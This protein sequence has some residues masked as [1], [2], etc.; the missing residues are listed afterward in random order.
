MGTTQFWRQDWT[1]AVPAGGGG[2]GTVTNTG[3]NLTANSVVLGAGTVDTKV[4]AGIITDGTS[5]LTLGVAGT[6]AGSIDFKNATSGT[7]TL[8]PV[9]GALGTVT[10]S[11]PATT[12]TIL[13][14]A[15]GTL[16]GELIVSASTGPTDIASVGFRGSPLNTQNAAYTFVLTDSGKTIFHDEVT[17]TYTIPANSSVAYPIGTVITIVNNNGAGAITLAITTDTLRRGDGTAGTGSRTIASDSVVT[18]QKTKSTEWMITGK[19]TMV[20]PEIYQ[21]L[22]ESVRTQSLDW[23]LPKAA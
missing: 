8:A 19:F 15:G 20:S 16:T 1:L 13:T 7:I 6:S 18:I 22:I 3:G 23:S 21:R 12:G 14:T 10:V 5:K 17:A 11:L 9:T 4:V 2:S